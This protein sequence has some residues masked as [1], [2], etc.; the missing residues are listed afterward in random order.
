MQ[1]EAQSGK[2]LGMPAYIVGR[3]FAY[4]RRKFAKEFRAGK[5]I[6]SQRQEMRYVEGLF[7]PDKES[8]WW[9]YPDDLPRALKFSKIIGYWDVIPGDHHTTWPQWTYLCVACREEGSQT[10][11]ALDRDQLTWQKLWELEGSPEVHI[12]SYGGL[13]ITATLCTALFEDGVSS[14]PKMQRC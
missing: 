6:C 1:M 7:W 9:H 2:Y 14:F 10:H 4:V 13:H 5:N 8:L 3:C 11:R 12:I